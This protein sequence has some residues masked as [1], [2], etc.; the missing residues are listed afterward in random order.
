MSSAHP[1][2]DVRIFFKECVSLAN[3]FHPAGFDV[4]VH[5]ILSGVEERTDQNVRIHSVEHHGGS[6]LKRMWST[7]N[8]VYRKAI[9][10]DG[11]I[12]HFHDP[13]LLR[14]ALKLK[15]AGKKVIY[16]VHEDVPKQI[17]DK[18]WIPKWFRG[19]VSNMYGLFENK[20]ANKLNGIVT[21]TPLIEERFQKVNENVQMV[22][23]YPLLSETNKINDLIVPK[24]KNQICY[25]G[26]LFPTRGVK[27]L[28][29]ALEFTDA[30][31]ILAGTFSPASF[32]NEVKKLKGWSK[33]S[34]L[35]QI[36][37]DQIAEVL[38]SSVAGIVTLHPTRSY[39]E[40]LPIKMFE[41]MSAG[42]P[43]VASNF[44]YWKE[45]IDSSECGVCADPLNPKDIAG[46]IQ[47]LL[48]DPEKSNRL[49]GNGL[50]AFH[51]KYNWNAEEKKLFTLY[52]KLIHQ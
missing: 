33:V 20:R 31:L 17:M 6:R 40:S 43:M 5:L 13:E 28:I 51:E 4:E 38:K 35:G 34:Y 9:E 3:N 24:K 42:I 1:D 44:E 36:E 12:Y 14:I 10:L 11:D 7:V 32:E 27:E 41:Y 52:E 23:N 21:V 26:G 15:R 2:K 37:R 29:Q 18:H 8:N 47:D 16:D 39:K 45:I 25:V 46:K 22:A 50:K 48:S 49:G 19:F 30:Q